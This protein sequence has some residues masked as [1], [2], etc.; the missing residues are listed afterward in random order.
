MVFSKVVL[1][2]AEIVADANCCSEL[3]ALQNKYMRLKSRFIFIAQQ[4]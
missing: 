3:K 1:L 4:N 2:H